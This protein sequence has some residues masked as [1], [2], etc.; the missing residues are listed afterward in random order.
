M[1]AP[2]CPPGLP[3]GGKYYSE[4]N[5][6][7][8]RDDSFFGSKAVLGQGVGYAVVLGFGAFFAFFTTFLVG[9][10]NLNLP[11]PL[12]RNCNLHDMSIAVEFLPSTAGPM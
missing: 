9:S 8:V 10:E 5:G 2:V 11:W 6:Q 3:W 7:C 12:N 4:I 1:A